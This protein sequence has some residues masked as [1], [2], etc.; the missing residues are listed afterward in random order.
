[1]INQIVPGKPG[2]TNPMIPIPRNT[3]PSDIRVIFFRV[4]SIGGGDMVVDISE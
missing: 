2:T 3:I 4:L 1:M